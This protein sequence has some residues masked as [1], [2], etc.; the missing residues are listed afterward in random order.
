MHLELLYCPFG[1]EIS[2]KNP[3]DPE[4]SL[5]YLEKKA[6]KSG[7]DG[8]EVGDLEKTTKQ[9]KRNVIVRGVLSV[10]VI[11]AED[12]PAVDLMGKADPFVVLI[13]KKSE[14]KA[15]T[16]VRFRFSNIITNHPCL[17]N[18]VSSLEEWHSSKFFI[19][20]LLIIHVL[21]VLNPL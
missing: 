9:K 1:T 3:S 7:V 2:F 16:R 14:T 18:L 4:N 10:T 20:G 17:S 8:T 11:A 12:L 13:M 6:L 15:K 21:E 19:V 5:T